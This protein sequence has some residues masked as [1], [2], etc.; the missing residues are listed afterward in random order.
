VPK[1]VA[2]AAAVVAAVA[3][4]PEAAEVALVVEAEDAQQAPSGALGLPS[5]SERAEATPTRGPSSAAGGELFGVGGWKRGPDWAAPHRDHF[6]R[7]RG[8]TQA[9]AAPAPASAA[10]AP[11]AFTISCMSISP[12][13]TV[14]SGVTLDNAAVLPPPNHFPPGL[15]CAAWRLGVA[16]LP[17]GMCAAFEVEA[18]LAMVFCFPAL[19]T[20][21]GTSGLANSRA[22]L[23]ASQSTSATNMRRGAIGT[24]RRC[25]YEGC[26]GECSGLFG[27]C[28]GTRTG[29]SAKA[30]VVLLVL[31][32]PGAL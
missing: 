18:G 24:E 13:T 31:L 16:A 1:V 6:A 9:T 10:A 2:P 22:S 11:P 12:S 21:R 20:A 25:R 32:V 5:L 8:A 17:S 14:R 3:A 28:I 4:A 7:I 26:W 23:P 19:G 29:S 15:G 30:V 27:T